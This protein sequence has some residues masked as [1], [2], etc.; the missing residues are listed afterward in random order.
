MGILV[1]GN[2]VSKINYKPWKIK[3]Y[4]IIISILIL[5][6]PAAKAAVS[7]SI[8]VPDVTAEAAVLLDAGSGQ[9]LFEKNAR[10]RRP[11][12]STTKIM[13]ALLALEG[14]DLHQDVTVSPWA[15]SVGEASLDLRAGEQ[16]TLEDLIYG[17]LLESG[18]DACVAIAEH[19]AGTEPNFVM[20]MNQKA[21]LLG[22][23]D[24]SFKNTNGLPAEGH[25]TTAKDLAV[26]TR[27]ALENPVFK[28][29]VSTRDKIIGGPGERYLNNTNRLLWS[30]SWADGVKTGTTNEA[31]QCL[32]ASGTINGRQII[33]VVL[34]S[35]N[36]WSDSIKLLNYG[37]DNFESCRV[38]GEGE[39]VAEIA[40][41]EG[42]GQQVQGVTGAEYLVVVP[43][44]RLDLL[45][46]K[47]LIEEELNA[48]VAKGSTVGSISIS[49]NGVQ[50][51]SVVLLSDR[52]IKRQSALRIFLERIFKQA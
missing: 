44:G 23:E 9:V 39:A 18:N 12:A 21:K 47:Y 52:D 32:V 2:E 35:E 25:Y 17:A 28:K 48:P 26:I 13:T 37:Y 29:I 5:Y 42:S 24:T 7:D 8:A 22:A 41:K 30:F 27:Y 38:F 45:E 49:V 3:F 15:A 4:L 34:N 20:L 11:P 36:R 10:Q 46:K 33:S 19:I 1:V 50:V 43:K 16:L 6:A 31:G 51:G 14:G 40:V